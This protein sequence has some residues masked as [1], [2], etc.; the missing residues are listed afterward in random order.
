[1][2]EEYNLAEDDFVI[3]MMGGGMGLIPKEISFYKWINAHKHI[4]LIIITGHNE[5]LY[6]KISRYNDY[7]NIDVLK[8]TNRVSDMM[9]LSD[10][11]ITK[12]GGITL[13]ETIS[14]NLPFIIY[15]PV[16]GQ[17][18]ENCRY[19]EEKELGYIVNNQ[20]EL[21]EKISLVMENDTIRCNIIKKLAIQKKNINMK[22]LA[23]NIMVLYNQDKFKDNEAR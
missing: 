3:L 15:K 19:I 18:L 21:K 10:L 13:F 20:D 17:E 1:M 8:Y 7:S 16:L 11:L 14:S 22:A 9:A 6:N 12:P 5:D 23:E 4:K 2:R